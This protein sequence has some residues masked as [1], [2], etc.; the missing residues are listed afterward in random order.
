MIKKFL[1]K[2]GSIQKNQFLSVRHYKIIRWLISRENSGSEV[3]GENGNSE[4]AAIKLLEC[5]IQPSQTRNCCTCDEEING[6]FNI[7]K[8]AQ[9]ENKQDA[10]IAND[11]RRINNQSDI[12]W[13]RKIRPEKDK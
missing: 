12:L 10:G 3:L 1:R 6:N 13:F 9:W 7:N 11:F 2:N 8:I 4:C 5:S